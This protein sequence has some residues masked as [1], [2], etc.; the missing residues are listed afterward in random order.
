M[1]YCYLF[2]LIATDYSIFGTFKKL[3]ILVFLTFVGHGIFAQTAE[4]CTNG[5]D[6]DGDGLIDC[7]DTD[8]TCTGQC[9]DFYYTTCNPDCYYIPPCNNISLGVQWTG[10][11][12][13]GTYSPIVAGDMDGDGV[14]EVVTY[15]NEQTQIYIADG[16][17]GLTKVTITSPTTLPGGTAPAIADLDNDGFGELV[18][19]GEDRRLRCYEHN[20]T[21]KYTSAVQVGYD[22]RYRFSVPNIAD[23][24][25]DGLAEVNI[26]NQVFNGQTGALLASGGVGLSAGEH[27]KRRAIGFSFNM[28]VPMDV[29]PDSFCPDCEGL[30]IV[31]G[32]QVLSVN[33]QTGVVTAVVT[34]PVN[35]TDGFTSVADIDRDGDL[36]A[37]VQGQRG[38]QNV[39]YAWDI[40]TPTILREFQLLNNYAEGA[41]RVNV[42]DLNG[43]GQ[44]EVTFVSFPWLYALRNN[45]TE[46]WK[47]QT[48]DAS[49]VTCSSV[50]DFCGDGTA[51][52][53]YRGQDFLQ[54]I[55]GATGQVKWQDAC[56]S[57]THIENPLILD[58]DADGQTEVVIQCGS[59]FGEG[60]VM[61]YEA[62]G[63]PSIAS[64]KVWNQH[65]YFSTNINEDLSVPRI[66]QNPHIVADSLRM[67][68]F[69]NQ[70]FNPSFPS[71]DGL[72]AFENVVCEEDSLRIT[73][74]IC[75]NGDNVLPL[76]M[77]ISAYRGNPLQ[78]AATWIGTIPLGVTIPLG[79]CV[80]RSFAVPRDVAIND[81][82]YLALNDDHS[83]V[84]PYNISQFPVTSLGECGFNNNFAKFYYAY[85][86]DV[87]SLGADTTI[88]DNATVAFSA[89]GNQ[90]VSFL[91][92]NGTTQANFTAPDAGIYHVATTDICGIIQRDTVQIWI[93][94]STVVNIGPDVT[95]CQ[96][97]TVTLS[98]SG[99]DTYQWTAPPGLNCTN[100]AS[101]EAGLSATGTIVLRA[102][103]ANGCF[104]TDTLVLTVNDTF[105]LKIDTVVCANRTL[106][107]NGFQ[108]L[109]NTER[110]F[111]L[112]TVL[113]CDSTVLVQV[114]GLDT[115]ATAEEV[116]ICPGQSYTIFGQSQNTT[117][118]YSK[119][120]M[121]EN[122]CDS[123]HRVNLIVQ[124]QI[125]V[126]AVA[127]PTCF[128]VPT[129]TLSATA[130]GGAPPFD[131]AWSSPLVGGVASA[132]ELPAG[133]Y[134][135]TVTD[136]N[137]CT[138][139]A[140]A[141]ISSHPPIEFSL[142]ADSV[143]CFGQTNGR[144]DISTSDTTLL[145]SLDGQPFISGREFDD[146]SAGQYSIVA[147]NIFGCNDTTDIQVFE[148][149]PMLVLL[150]ADTSLL[151]GDSLRM[152]ILTTGEA[153]LRLVWSDTSFLSRP[154]DLVTYTRPLKSLRYQ[155]T[156]TD[157]NG[158]IAS[159][160]ITISVER[161][162]QVFVPNVFSM[163]AANDYNTRMAPGFGSSVERVRSL[164]VFDRWGSLMFGVE[165]ALPGDAALFWDGRSRNKVVEPGVYIWQ[166]AV[167][168]VDGTVVQ[169]NGDVTVIR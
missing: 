9:D 53:V 110:I 119:L 54:I 23:F 113:N 40:Q 169:Y 112:Q 143:Q 141:S 132:D 33:L 82:I 47:V 138:Q 41:S 149:A 50:F 85:N 22:L 151:L 144:I 125:A 21:L 84:T 6:D 58:V 60:R 55:E 1:H 126:T 109:P 95:M 74:E 37:I 116:V 157:Q 2:L 162:K 72:M 154:N 100:C 155:L 114:M 3:T 131:Y 27:P 163:T 134:T 104:S 71:P 32:N 30:E 160:Q 83:V 73:V 12:E 128:N 18:I 142:L 79:G 52:I 35:Y 5:I 118:L 103:L 150:P 146:L 57:A 13:T 51:D 56:S 137:D 88:C 77:P 45:F 140:T 93:D 159:D 115:F 86:P 64:R 65:C 67:N 69:L 24:N 39:C 111:N 42:A 107:F 92:Q 152:E 29:L 161:I 117:G 101:V 61:C 121:A 164:Q 145:F 20:G 10:Q 4:N 139:T 75:N 96:G 48:F 44:L 11:A 127:T 14:P 94:S 26:G 124:P 89:S 15:K 8:C 59:G 46:L 87:V 34:A 80:Q 78:T 120:F 158:C 166:I 16:A 148:P 98:E 63:T 108:L 136:N 43:D 62:V 168:L 38:N 81:T 90:L 31:A 19:V 7:Y 66:Q 70:F 99:F 167:E 36:D 130:T 123:T 91:W 156:I 133:N 122:G 97:E 76:Q 153:P 129:G 68:T 49:S 105:Y 28:P 135:I 17:T 25:H 165:N 102:E 147:E 106:P